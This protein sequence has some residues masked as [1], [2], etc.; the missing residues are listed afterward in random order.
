MLGSFGAK[1]RYLRHK[2]GLTQRELSRA[3]GLTG[4]AAVS[5]LEAGRNLPSIE[6]VL[7]LADL[8]DVTTDY[9]VRDSIPLDTPQMY[10]GAKLSPD[11]LRSNI[12][13]A[14]LRA[15]RRK[16][17]V[18]QVELAQQLGL[19]RQGYISNL[20]TSRIAPSLQL[21]VRI[22]DLFKV[23]TDYLL[24]DTLPVEAVEYTS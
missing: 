24:R 11:Q 15:L 20:E 19:R 21:V 8:F 12:F 10:T 18:L 7:R 23:S 22:A 1:L 16:H 5:S 2:H 9:L 4:H 17:Q 6:L 3:I 14:K 13:G